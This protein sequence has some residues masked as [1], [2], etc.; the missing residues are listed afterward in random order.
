LLRGL[1]L[2]AIL[3]L[4]LQGQSSGPS[5][6]ASGLVNG[7]TYLPGPLAPNTW[8]TLRGSNLAWTT[9]T[10]G[11]ADMT[12]DQWPVRIPGAGVQVLFAGGTPAHLLYVSPTQINFLTPASRVP[13]NTTL[14]VVRDGVAGPSIPVTFADTAPGLFQN[15]S[16]AVAAHADGSVITD[17]APARPGEIVVLYGTGLG[18]TVVPLDSQSDGRLV[19]V[20]SNPAAL[21][22][23]RFAD[24]SVTLN[25]STV[26]PRR[27]LWAGLTPGFAGLY[28]INLQLPDTLEAN[29]FIRIRMGDQASAEGV[30]LAVRP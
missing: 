12:G 9:A 5:Y 8:V 30:K 23:L 24:L 15:N 21:R 19:A 14:I 13:G 4:T 10:A 7:A 16:M 22:I 20:N 29:P 28:Q 3:T 27:I 6:S 17:D 2:P 25:D 11:P 18:Q 1:F 26:D